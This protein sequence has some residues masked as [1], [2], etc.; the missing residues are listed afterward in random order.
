M[1]PSATTFNY[2]YMLKDH[3]GNVRVVLTEEQQQDIYPAATLENLTFN[4]GTAITNES[5][6]YNIDNTKIVT[7]ATA[8]GI[9]VYQ[10]NN[11]IT[12]NNPYSNT[13][14]NSARLYQLN[15]TTNTVANKNGLGIVLK[16]MA[17]D[18]LN[19]FGKSYH[20][21][22]TAGY[23]L[24]SSPLAVIDLMN[25]FA[26]APA[27]SGKGIT[28]TQITGQ[29]GF[30]TSV[31]TLLNNQPS[32]TTTTPRAS[33]NWIILDEQFKYVSG[34]FDMVGTATTATGTYKNHVIN[35]ITIP[36]NG[37]IYVYCSNESQ[38]N[39][40]FDNLQVTHTRGPLLEETHY[41]PFGLTMAGISSR[42]ANSLDNKYEYNGKEKQ[43]K[44]FS[45][46]S[47]LELYDFDARQQDPQIGRW[48]SI[49]PLADK[50]PN[51]SPYCT[52]DNNP[53]LKND[54]TGMAANPIY[55]QETGDFLGTDDK[56]LKGGAIVMDKSKFTQ[57]MKH[58]DAVNAGS[59]LD[60]API[61][62]EAYGKIENFQKI[63]PTRPDYDGFVTITEGVDWAK[64][65]VGAL[66][67][68]TPENT[69]YIDASKLDFGNTATSDFTK[70]I[71]VK[72]PI[73][74]FSAGNVTASA[75]NATLRATVY[76]LGRVDMQLLDK[77]TGAV[78][79]I[80]NPATDYDWNTGGGIMRNTFIKT[81]RV[82]TGLNDS[83]G[84]KTY[85]YGTGKLNMSGSGGAIVP[86]Y[87]HGRIM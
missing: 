15:A 39:V 34:G 4:G 33:I 78:K 11:G 22:P 30:P 56:G 65:H 24:A 41:Y 51:Q 9:P 12:N 29:S 52:M 59:S 2:D 80:N 18:N 38:Y 37:Y 54:P 87:E 25:L 14:V 73:N 17:G 45:D 6:Y 28:G 1:R 84:F 49:D 79:I 70:G 44:E 36:K 26:G 53:I 10:N 61:S 76:A 32:Q 55:D 23:T 13:A 48:T 43:E 21:K 74:L 83:H 63:I 64:S 62:G 16:V 71:N 57:G 19:I 5:P 31:T 58:S 72:T 40:F 46:G 66:Q 7:Q 60:R 20:K 50:F 82:R 69:L 81:E 47:G 75:G 42:A 27:L 86:S 3:L 67:N 8:A 35:G 85:Y 77:N 68:P